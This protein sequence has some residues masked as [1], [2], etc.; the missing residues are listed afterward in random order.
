MVGGGWAEGDGWGGGGFN[1]IVLGGISSTDGFSSPPPPP[2][3]PHP[4]SAMDYS[5]RAADVN[6]TVTMTC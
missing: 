3:P 6:S 5:P 4:F 1:A 2:P